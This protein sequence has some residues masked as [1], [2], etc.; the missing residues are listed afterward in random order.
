MSLA[1]L[2][3]DIT[4][5]LTTCSLGNYCICLYF[6]VGCIVIIYAIMILR[7]WLKYMI[8]LLRWSIWKK[9]QYKKSVLQCIA[10]Y[11]TS[12]ERVSTSIKNKAYF[13]FLNNNVWLAYIRTFYIHKVTTIHWRFLIQ[14]NILNW[15]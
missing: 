11:I 4:Y 1:V 12:C 2:Y 3:I 15:S 6:Y 7:T 9:N 8:Q 10:L 5:L 14:T 13:L